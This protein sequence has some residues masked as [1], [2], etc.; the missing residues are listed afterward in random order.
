MIETETQ[1]VDVPMGE[2]LESL[3]S[4]ETGCLS[5]VKRAAKLLSTKEAYVDSANIRCACQLRV[6]AL[7]SPLIR[8][9]LA[10]VLYGRRAMMLF[11]ARALVKIGIICGECDAFMLLCLL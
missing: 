9:M 5:T 3:L 11:N 10:S 6:S 4:F 7:L 1:M 8:Y 2:D